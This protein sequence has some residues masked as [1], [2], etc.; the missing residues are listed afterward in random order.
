[1]VGRNVP[2]CLLPKVFLLPKT[3]LIF[4]TTPVPGLLPPRVTFDGAGLVRERSRV[5]P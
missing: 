5:K 2:I 4:P 1:L 3:S